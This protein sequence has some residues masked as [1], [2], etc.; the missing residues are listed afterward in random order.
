MPA[1]LQVPPQVRLDV[2]EG[3]GG[4]TVPEVDLTLDCRCC[5]TC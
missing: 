3:R 1:D 2:D 4:C 5:W